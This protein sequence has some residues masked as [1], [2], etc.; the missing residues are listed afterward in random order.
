MKLTALFN[1]IRYQNPE[2]MPAWKVLRMATIEG[3]R[4]IGLGDQIGSL[5]P[6]KRADFILIDLNKPS[7]LPTF[8]EPMRNIVPNLVYSARGDEVAIVAVDGQII[9]EQGQILTV[10][11]AEI[12]EQAQS[13]AQPLGPKAAE[14]FWRI[15]GTNAQ[16]MREDKL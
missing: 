5:A 2:V 4:A 6:D 16:F 9:Y 14:E 13:L 8:T 12:L 7:M 15:N 11:E 1:K 10:D 3:A